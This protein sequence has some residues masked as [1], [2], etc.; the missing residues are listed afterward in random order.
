MSFENGKQL[1]IPEGFLHGFATRAP[2][3]EIIYKCT[4]YYAPECDGAVRFDDPEIG[5]DWGMDA[6]AAVLSEKD[7]KAPL[8]KDFDSPFVWEGAA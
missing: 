3:T 7:A 5:I 4:D 8:L 2:D 1:Y 6:G